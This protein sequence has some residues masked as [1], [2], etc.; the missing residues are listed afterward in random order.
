M[1]F[2]VNGR[3]RTRYLDIEKRTQ[4]FSSP[5]TVEVQLGEDD[6][7]FQSVGGVEWNPVGNIMF[8]GKNKRLLKRRDEAVVWSQI[9]QATGNE[10]RDLMFEYALQILIGGEGQALALGIENDPLGLKQPGALDAP[11]GKNPMKM[12]DTPAGPATF[13]T[14]PA[15]FAHSV[16]QQEV[17][18]V[19]IAKD[20][21]T[22]SGSVNVAKQLPK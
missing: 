16:G 2:G 15:R 5:V 12:K 1:H 17:R 13:D 19:E 22:L 6:V 8:T 18:A 3:W 20:D 11:D 10:L 21:Y 9:A 4:A 7:L 14:S